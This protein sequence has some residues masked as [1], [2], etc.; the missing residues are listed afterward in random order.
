MKT[1]KDYYN[2]Y[3]VDEDHED[4]KQ[5]AVIIIAGLLTLVM[6]ILTIYWMI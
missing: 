2:D 1:R 4:L 6:S 5:L 3:P